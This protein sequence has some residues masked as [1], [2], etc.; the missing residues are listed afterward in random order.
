M[1]PRARRLLSRVAS[2]TDAEREEQRRE[3][4]R[5]T[6]RFSLADMMALAD[7]GR[8]VADTSDRRLEYPSDTPQE[9]I[10]KL[11]REHREEIQR[12]WQ[13]FRKTFSTVRSTLT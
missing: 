13:K 6:L 12:G 11:R 4:I 3:E 10:D 9:E 8:R 1:P 5:G 2:R 7:L